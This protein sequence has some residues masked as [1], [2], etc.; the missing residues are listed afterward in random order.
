MS[1][2]AW[3]LVDGRPVSSPLQ[4]LIH[5]EITGFSSRIS[6]E[7]GVFSPPLRKIWKS[8]G[9]MKF[10]TE[11][12]NKSHV[13]NYQPVKI[14]WAHQGCPWCFHKKDVAMWW[15]AL[16]RVFPEKKCWWGEVKNVGLLQL[17]SSCWPVAI[18]SILTYPNQLVPNLGWLSRCRP[19]A[20][21]HDQRLACV[22]L[23]IPCNCN[24]YWENVVL[25]F[26][27]HGI[28]QFP[29]YI[30]LF[31]PASADGCAHR[32]G[33]PTCLRSQMGRVTIKIVVIEWSFTN[34]DGDIMGI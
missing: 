34:H 28:S 7:V 14:S 29:V 9:M 30:D 12:K 17:Q 19:W 11:W 16:L 32:C 5:G 26:P 2:R 8:V 10:P 20:N 1:G 3:H 31:L 22:K 33:D 4:D 27:F 15:L 21:A 6:T 23:E 25:I 13:P 24:V 18:T